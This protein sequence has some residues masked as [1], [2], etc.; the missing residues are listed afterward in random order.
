MWECG[1]ILTW[2]LVTY[3]NNIK[4]AK[5]TRPVSTSCHL[6]MTLYKKGTRPVINTYLLSLH[7]I[8]RSWYIAVYMTKFSKKHVLC[9]FITMS[10]SNWKDWLTVIIKMC[11]DFNHLKV[12]LII[13]IILIS[14]GW[15]MDWRMTSAYLN[16]G[17]P[18]VEY[19]VMRLFLVWNLFITWR[20]W[21]HHHRV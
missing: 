6:V 14:Y 21:L 19:D 16:L 7:V 5:S 17:M 4:T 15:R 8:W 12:F 13:S 11:Q 2:S 10:M 9:F 20:V 1:L 18:L 3:D